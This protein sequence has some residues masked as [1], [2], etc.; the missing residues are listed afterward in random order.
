MEKV[1]R[2]KRHRYFMEMWENV[3]PKTEPEKERLYYE[4]AMKEKLRIQ[5]LEKQ[6]QFAIVELF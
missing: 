2:E 6:R 1:F 4:N 5:E 3:D